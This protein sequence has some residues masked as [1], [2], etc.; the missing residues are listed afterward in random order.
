M[1]LTKEER[2]MFSTR[3]R[4][5]GLGDMITTATSALPHESHVLPAAAAT[6]TQL[7]TA[8]DLWASLTGQRQATPAF[9]PGQAGTQHNNKKS[10]STAQ[11]ARKQGYYLKK[12]EEAKAARKS[13]H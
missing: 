5:T 11:K 13:K 8:D 6:A 12:R 3:W 10:K 9:S 7:R 1:K 2:M 4:G